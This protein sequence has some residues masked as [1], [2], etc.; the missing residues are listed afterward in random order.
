MRT[1]VRPIIVH[2]MALLYCGGDSFADVERGFPNEW[3]DES[4][5]LAR[6]NMKQVG[7]PL[8]TG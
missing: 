8:L 1:L 4:R 6:T 3:V 2:L 5:Q 7:N